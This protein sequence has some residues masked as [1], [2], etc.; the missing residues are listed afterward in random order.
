MTAHSNTCVVASQLLVSRVGPRCSFPAMTLPVLVVT[1]LVALS[2]QALSQTPAAPGRA[3]APR[4]PDITNARQS[5]IVDAAARVGPAAVSVNVLR[6]QRNIARNPFESFFLPPGYERTIEG[7]GSGFVLTKD[8]VVITNQHVTD[9]AEQIVVTT[10][11]GRDYPAR[12]LGEDPL[13]DI[14]VLKIEGSDLA[15]APICSSSDLQI[16]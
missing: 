3:R 8:G 2:S 4:G 7:F 5:A 6:R 13:T 14:A 12:L 16:G 1:A 10:R 15:T 11:D 9:G